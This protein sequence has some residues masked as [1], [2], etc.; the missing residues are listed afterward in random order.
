MQPAGAGTEGDV[1]PLGVLGDGLRAIPVTGATVDTF[2]PVERRHAVY[3]GSNGLAGAKLD[4]DLGAAALAQFGVEEN[5]MVAIARRRLDF[6]T[7]EQ[8]VLMR[9]QQLAVI[10]YRRPAAPLH[11]SAVQRY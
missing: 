6:A 9:H 4:T 2:L 3:A 11:E 10:G 8:R 5:N 7:E 1:H